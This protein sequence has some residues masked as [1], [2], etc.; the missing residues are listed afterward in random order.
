MILSLDLSILPTRLAVCRLE[1]DAPIPAW[2]LSGAFYTLSRTPDE[3]SIVCPESVV[4]IGTRAE[5]GWR[6]LK[7]AGHL[8]FTLTGILA[9]LAG[10][11]AQ[12]GISLFAISTFDTDYILVKEND[13]PQAIRALEQAG[14]RVDFH[15]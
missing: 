9:G 8:D 13:L 15:V 1:R 14:H 11:L 4:P 3:L 12:A 5:S 10:A 6:A 7:V 2:S